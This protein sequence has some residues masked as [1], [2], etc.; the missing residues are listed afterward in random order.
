VLPNTDTPVMRVAAV[1][2]PPP[3]KIPVLVLL[4]VVEFWMLCSAVPA[5]GCATKPKVLVNALLKLT[6]ILLKLPASAPL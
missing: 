5:A 2:A 4:D 1:P 6:V 3:E